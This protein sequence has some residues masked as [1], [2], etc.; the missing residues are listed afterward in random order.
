MESLRHHH[1]PHV[2]NTFAIDLP[3]S[4]QQVKQEERKAR[5]RPS[6]LRI[7]IRTFTLAVGASILAVLAQSVAVWYMTRHTILSQPGKLP[8]PGWPSTMDLK[9]TYLM[10]AAAGIAVII[11]LVA[12]FTLV[13]P[14][15]SFSR[16][17]CRICARP[18]I[19]L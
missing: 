18:S 4:H 12:F 19:N 2:D 14:V 6:L 9:P 17:A 3:P 15:S 1:G 8:Q 16:C 11:Q 13:G 7:I 10:L 5:A